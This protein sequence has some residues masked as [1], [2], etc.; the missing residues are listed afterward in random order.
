M[1]SFMSGYGRKKILVQKTNSLLNQ[2]FSASKVLTHKFPG[3][4]TSFL[5]PANKIVFFARSLLH[6]FSSEAIRMD[7]L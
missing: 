3:P 6:V 2:L 1:F 7:W 4:F 5:N